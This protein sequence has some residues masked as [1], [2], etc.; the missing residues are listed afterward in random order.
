[1]T[2]W[3]GGDQNQA[4]AITIKKWVELILTDREE[5]MLVVAYLKSTGSMETPKAPHMSHMTRGIMNGQ[6]E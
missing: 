2:E 4:N 3:K 6:K 5:L 1:M